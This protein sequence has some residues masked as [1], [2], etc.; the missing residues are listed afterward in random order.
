[1]RHAPAKRLWC[2]NARE[3]E[4]VARLRNG[5]LADF[6]DTD[7]FVAQALRVLDD[8]AAFRPPGERAA[9][10][11]RERYSAGVMLPRMLALYRRVARG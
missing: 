5:L 2:D 8:P 6:F 9:E 1:M 11:I 10:T 7:A 4:P 3:G